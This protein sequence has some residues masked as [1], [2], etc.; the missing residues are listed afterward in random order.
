M[1]AFLYGGG[2]DSVIA[3]GTIDGAEDWVQTLGQQEAELHF[4]R[5][6]RPALG[7]PV[8]GCATAPITPQALEKGPGEVESASFDVVSFQ[9]ARG[10]GEGKEVGQHLRG[11]CPST[12]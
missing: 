9:N 8:T 2:V 12:Q 7:W 4:I 5:R 6:N 10:I 1:P 3:N 11:G